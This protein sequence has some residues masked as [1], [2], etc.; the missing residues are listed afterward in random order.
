MREKICLSLNNKKQA[1]PTWGWGEEKKVYNHHHHH[2]H[3]HPILLRE[4][5]EK[6][7]YKHTH[8]M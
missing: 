6:S 2:H 4:E 3:H 5:T 8:V 7:I 1:D